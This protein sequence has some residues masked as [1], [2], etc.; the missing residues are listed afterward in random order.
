MSTR[1]LH[2]GLTAHTAYHTMEWDPTVG[3]KVSRWKITEMRCRGERKRDMRGQ[4]KKRGFNNLENQSESAGSPIIS[5]YINKFIT[6]YSLAYLISPIF[7]ISF[8]LPPF[9]LLILHR[10]ISP[11]SPSQ[12]K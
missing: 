6:L 2:M 8:L 5:V 10:S 1:C 3:P 11:F 12:G 9:S 7:F 4:R